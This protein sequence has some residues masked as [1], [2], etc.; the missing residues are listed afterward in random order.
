VFSLDNGSPVLKMW[1]HIFEEAD[2]FAVAQLY[3]L[4]HI[5]VT[6]EVLKAVIMTS[7]SSWDVMPRSPLKVNRRF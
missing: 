3:A 6:S 5:A 4:S 2:E 7:P 1:T